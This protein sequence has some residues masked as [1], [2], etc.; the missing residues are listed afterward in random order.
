ML[1]YW[2]TIN[3]AIIVTP[4]S[5]GASEAALA[6]AT[7]GLDDDVADGFA[8]PVGAGFTGRVAAE[9]KPMTLAASTATPWPI[10]TR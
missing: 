7:S 8:I 5:S 9:R 2:W 4:A 3:A 1:R 10:P 6:A